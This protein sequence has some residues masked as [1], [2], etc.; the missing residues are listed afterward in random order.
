[1]LWRYGG[2]SMWKAAFHPLWMGRRPA[3]ELEQ[4]SMVWAVEQGLVAG[5]SNGRLNP[6]GRPLQS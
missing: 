5:I 1:M 2:S 4:P 6:R 3:V